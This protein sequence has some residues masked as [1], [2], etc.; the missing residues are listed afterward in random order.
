MHEITPLDGIVQRVGDKANVTYSTGYSK[1]GGS[2]LV[3]RAVSAA[4]QA[5]VAIVIAGL[6][7]ARYLDDEGWDRKDLRL[8]YGQDELIR[9]VVQANPRTIVVLVAG[10]ALELDPWLEKVPALLQTWYSGMEGGHA[11]ARVLFG[12]VNPSG[13]LTCTYPRRL[14]DSPAHA[15]ETYPGTDGTLF[16]KEGLL[17]GYR[18]FD[19]RNIEPLFPFGYGLSYTRFDYSGL[20]LNGCADAKGPVL[21]VELDVT[22]TGSRPGAEVV[23]VYV[24][25][26]NPRLSRPVK[27]LKGFQKV[28]LE[29]NQKRTVSIP[30]DRRAFAYYDPAQHG[31]VSEKGAYTVMVG[32]SSRDIRQQAEFNLPETSI[33]R[34]D[35]T[36]LSP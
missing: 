33:Q 4:R 29:P 17:V 23:Q 32:A 15:L 5:D 2:N 12:D 35:Q 20:K 31:W 25:Q 7:H 26:A 1:K 24:H 16:F 10:P 8:P 22:N 11:L 19:T 36:Y 9:R 27:E 14:I 34:Q 28:L 13:K 18:W 30:L 21:T 6:G 3:E